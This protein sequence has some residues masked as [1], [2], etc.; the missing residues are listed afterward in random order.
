MNVYKRVNCYI[1]LSSDR[2]H[3]GGRSYRIGD[4]WQRPHDSAN[5]MLACVCLGNGKGEW[6]CKPVGKYFMTLSNH[7]FLSIIIPLCSPETNEK[8]PRFVVAAKGVIS[9]RGRPGMVGTLL[10]SASISQWLFVQE[11][12]N[13]DTS[14]SY[15]SRTNNSPLDI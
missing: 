8:R 9:D 3:E 1:V 11:L 5:Y 6:T 15:L 12:S 7:Y 14:Y 4:T 10:V 13:F 2:C